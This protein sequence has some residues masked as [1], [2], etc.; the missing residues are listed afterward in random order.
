MEISEHIS[1]IVLALALI[2]ALVIG[3]G[4][5]VKRLNQGSLS[6]AG[7]IKVVASTYLGP[8]E[9]ILLLE[10]RGRQVLVGVNPQ[11]I[12]A[13]CQFDSDGTRSA[14]SSFSTVLAEAR[15]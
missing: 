6:G 1:Q 5:L 13:L 2:I 10:V 7:E 8:K 4:L 3:L 9:K 11:S 15:S 14:Q 12:N